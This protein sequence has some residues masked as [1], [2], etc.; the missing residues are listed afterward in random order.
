MISSQNNQGRV[1]AYQPKLKAEA[2][3]LTETLIRPV[4]NVVL[5]PC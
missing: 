5:L 3:T 4:S 2:D 1:R